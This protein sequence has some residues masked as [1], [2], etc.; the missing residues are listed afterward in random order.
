M[1][2]ILGIVGY[3]TFGTLEERAKSERFQELGSISAA[4]ELRYDKAYQAAAITEV[5]VQDILQ[6][7]PE[8]CSRDAVVK[9]LKDSV[10][11][12]PGILGVGV[13]FAPDA[14]DGKD[15]EKVN[16]E[17]SD[18][19]GRLLPFVWPDRIEPLFGY[20]TAEWY[21]AAEKTMKP[22]LTDIP[23]PLRRPMGSTI[24]RQRCP[25]RSF[26][27]GSSSVRSSSISTWAASRAI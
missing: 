27:T 3:M 19:S 16:T 11:A 13:C 24:W 10:A 26:R 22:V 4:V 17:Y 20:E 5:R 21:T 2:I 15:A 23:T 1:A 25:T 9:V 14:F 6:A 12:T 7:P 8:A 18:A